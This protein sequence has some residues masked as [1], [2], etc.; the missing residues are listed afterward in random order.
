MTPYFMS[1]MV[2]ASGVV[3]ILMALASTSRNPKPPSPGGVEAIYHESFG[4]D[5]SIGVSLLFVYSV[6]DMYVFVMFMMEVMN[7]V[8]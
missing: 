6:S 3:Y 7:V 1:R 5:V 8:L 2:C 4:S